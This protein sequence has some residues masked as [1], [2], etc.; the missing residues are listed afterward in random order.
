M[1]TSEC[2]RPYCHGPVESYG[3][4]GVHSKRYWRYRKSQ[5][6]YDQV[7]A[8]AARY[9]AMIM[10]HRGWTLHQVGRA[11][12]MAAE[13]VKRL[14]DGTDTTLRRKEE[15]SLLATPASWRAS[16]VSIP[17][18]GSARRL[19]ALSWMGYH[20]GEIAQEIGFSISTVWQVKTLP[21]CSAKLG[22]A[23]AGFFDHHAHLPGP[24]P[25]IA[26]RSR[27]T[28]KIPAAAWP[29]DTAIDDPNAAPLVE[30]I[31]TGPPVR[32]RRGAVHLDDVEVLYTA[33]VTWEEIA[34]R[35]G[36]AERTVRDAWNREMHHREEGAA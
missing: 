34:A 9:H 35:L 20:K 36:V 13:R 26:A 10:R 4:C 33:G 7:D 28:G 24:W 3:L 2:S 19:D 21:T 11:A 18:I 8:A 29:S 25:S 6:D 17:S 22:V 23:V 30:M 15:T 16:R 14:L 12:H 32:I 31:R 5:G 27:T 1:P